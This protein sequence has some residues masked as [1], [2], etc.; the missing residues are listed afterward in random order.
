MSLGQVDYG[1]YGLVGGMIAFVTFLNGLLSSAI[2]R[3]YAVS[4]GAARIDG[5]KGLAQC[6]DWFSTAVCVH[7]VLPLVLVGIGYP[8]GL[9][10]VREF[11]TIPPDRIETCVWVWRFA[12]FG[13][14][15]GMVNVPFNAMYMAKQEIAELTVWSLLSTVC[16]FFLAFYMVE[17]PGDWLL[18]YSAAAC[19]ISVLPQIVICIRACIVYPECR[20]TSEGMF[21]PR[22]IRR[23]ASYAG[24]QVI[25][26]L[27]SL[28]KAQGIPIIINKYFGPRVNAAM[29]VAH[30]VSHHCNSLSASIQGAFTPAVMNAYGAGDETKARMLAYKTCKFGTMCALL[31]ALPLSLEINEV[32]RLW[33]KTP[34]R[35]AAGL[36]VCILAD[37][38]ID[39]SSAGISAMVYAKGAIARYQTFVGG[40]LLATLPIAWLLVHYGFGIYSI[41]F[42]IIFTK[43]FLAV[44]RVWLARGL[45]GVSARYW[46]SKVALP[47]GVV[48]LV[49]CLAG[50]VP[51]LALD[52]SLLRVT[53]TALLADAVFLAFCWILLFDPAE[54][55]YVSLRL[56]RALGRWSLARRPER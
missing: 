37:L 31:F 3:F 51:R 18:G 46:A 44:A 45:V 1:L 26:A 21:N 49:S 27:G 32:L 55:Q 30:S 41:G 47:I 52:A 50:L 24:W 35:Y 16:N 17:H 48:S 53:A 43:S 4:V 25:G 34:P 39:R 8:A 7:C 11:L 5:E 13:C 38:V 56:S 33:L 2:G 9:W 15:V 40:A 22:L 19:T 28:L 20:L 36:T 14:F 10:A 23:L 12:C 54:R 6:R 29:A 42:A